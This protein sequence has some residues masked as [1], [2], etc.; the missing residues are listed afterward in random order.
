M[1]AASRVLWS[2]LF[3]LLLTS[4][5]C[6]ASGEGDSLEAPDDDSPRWRTKRRVPSVDG[7]RTWTGDV[8]P[9]DGI[10]AYTD[11]GELPEIRDATGT[12]WPL[13]HTAVDADL[14][15]PF[16]EVQVVQ[17]FRNDATDAIEVVYVFPLPENAAVSQMRMVVGDRVIE[18]DIMRRADA[19]RTYVQ[20]RESGHTAALLEQERPNVFTQS[21]ANIPPGEDIDVEIHYVQTLTYDNGQY[22]F[23][24]PMVVAPRYNPGVLST[25]APS[26]EGAQPDTDRVPDASR[27]SP[28][29]VGEGTRRGDDF[30]I[31][32]TATAGHPIKS[33][34][35]PTH[36]VTV[37]R[38]GS[39]IA[40]ELVEAE[41]L[42]NRDFVLRYQAADVE[43]RAT[44]FLGPK[45]DNGD[46]HFALVVHPPDLDVDSLV[47]RREFMFV[48]DTSGSMTGAPLALAKEVIRSALPRLR[49]VDT[50]DVVSF[51]SGTR[52][53]FGAPRTANTANLNEALEFVDGLKAQ[54]GTEMGDAVE[55]A[56][57][58]DVAK[59]RHRYVMFLTDGHIGFESEIIAA[60]RRLTDEI[61]RR[62]QQ[63]RV[64]GVGIGSSPNTHLLNGLSRAGRG[65]SLRMGT[66]DNAGDVVNTFGRYVDHP[67]VSQL[68]MQPGSLT[69]DERHPQRMGD[70]FASHAVVTMGQYRGQ[71]STPPVV[72]GR[73]PGKRVRIPV[74]VVAAA[75]RAAVLDSLWARAAISDLE[76]D[77]WSNATQSTEDAITK[78][79]LDHHLVTAFTSLVA[80]DRSRVVG[81]GDPE[82]IVEPTLLPEGMDGAFVTTDR[83]AAGISLAGTT[84]AESSYAV[85]GA[86]IRQR[87]YSSVV[88]SNAVVS[89]FIGDG[90]KTYEPRARLVIGKVEAPAGVRRAAIRKALRRVS[91]G[92]RACYEQSSD[93]S[94]RGRFRVQVTLR[95]LADGSVD[96]ELS[97]SLDEG[98]EAC[99]LGQLNVAGIP[100]Q[101]VGTQVDLVLN[102]SGA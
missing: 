14:R 27:I 74:K 11:P 62:G 2:C 16:A 45:D 92:V 5:G 8:L 88:S 10:W 43:A 24:F 39:G 63:A 7:D 51:E 95:W 56:L 80:V 54:G 58:L 33:W 47:G 42:P 78:L 73:S 21:V 81:D 68:E 77:Y 17:T 64:F 70:L 90:R 76:F 57:N 25:A 50:F 31:T 100:T 28:P 101:D 18:S 94:R 72:V 97:S 60:A 93:F 3:A 53:L 49:P 38:T 30:T 23:A 12:P 13:L 79:G 36:D 20:A 32:V 48:V 29:V 61:G 40:V 22:E 96:V 52:R 19:K 82:L 69:L 91:F 75:P 34:T 102:L 66:R 87:S 65:V 84:A 35:V 15:G 67:I 41:T 44:M 99:V 83:D 9:D 26:G 86:N 1:L 59:G 37:D 71:A 4:V 85:P 6:A 55:A 89:E 98:T 46:G